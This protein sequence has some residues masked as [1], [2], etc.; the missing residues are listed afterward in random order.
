MP[1]GQMSREISLKQKATKNDADDVFE[2]YYAIYARNVRR[3]RPVDLPR[4]TMRAINPSTSLHVKGTHSISHPVS[5]H[6]VKPCVNPAARIPG[7]ATTNFSAA[8][9]TT[10]GGNPQILTTQALRI[11]IRYIATVS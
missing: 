7:A 5:I 6:R 2:A 3:R 10:S 1:A 4:T 8:A 11:Q 9:A